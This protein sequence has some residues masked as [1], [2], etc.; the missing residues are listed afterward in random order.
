VQG[1]DSGAECVLRLHDVAKAFSGIQALG[2]VSFDLLRG[3]VHALVGENGAG[4]STL[5]KIVAGAYVPDSGGIEIDGTTYDALSPD[6]AARLG[7]RVVY[8]DFN[9]VPE[10]SV[11]ENIFL[12]AQPTGRFGLLETTARRRRAAA[13]LERLGTHL[14][15]D[16]L[17]KHLTV[18]E[19]QIV[20]IAKA[21]ATDARILIMDEPSAVLPS[22]DMERLYGVI[23]AL[24]SA[25]TSIIYI[26]HR[27]DE[28]FQ[29]A[30]RV[31]VLKDGRSVMTTP[32]AETTRAELVNSMVGRQLIEQYP[33]PDARLGETLLEV[34][35]LCVEGCVYDASFTVHRGEIVGFAGLGGSGRS[36]VARALVGLAR[37][38]S[39][40]LRV[41]GHGAAANPAQAARLGVALI[42]EDRKAHGLVLSHSVR[43]NVTLP[44]L[45][46]LLRWGWLILRRREAA[47]VDG[48]VRRLQIRPPAI[49]TAVENLSGGNQQKVVLAK[50]L[51][52]QPRLIVLDEP[53]RGV[54]V[55]AKAEIYLRMRE[56][57]R[58]GVGIV[59]ISS[60]LPELLGMSDRILVFHEGRIAGELAGPAA[61]EAA[62]MHLATGSQLAEALPAYG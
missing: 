14:E 51:V 2:G 55:G 9:L 34:R 10:L 4:K 52:S 6:E 20:E 45:T 28:I 30:N 16:R 19:Q 25:G 17:V 61:T 1:L 58:D 22:H 32:V 27:L 59:M 47:L 23:R 62:V 26:S 31:T 5:I 49:E 12:G 57:T 43:F 50:W 46:R 8:Q 35:E 36:T 37:I 40:E 21:L 18:G 44:N 41:S 38:D 48:A 24:R 54:D 33:P 42:P 7:V 56:L 53:T 60:E 11:A 29:I 13:V 15:P 39:G 3:E